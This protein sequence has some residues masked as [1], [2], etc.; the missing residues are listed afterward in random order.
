MIK[1][2][3]IF[4]L[5]F[6]ASLIPYLIDPLQGPNHC[7]NAIKK[8]QP[9][10]LQSNVRVDSLFTR[11]VEDG[12]WMS[13]LVYQP[14]NVEMSRITVICLFEKQNYLLNEIEFKKGDFQKQ[15]KDISVSNY[16]PLSRIND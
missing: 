8:V 6:A 3:F 4:I 2:I 10:F 7:E 1:F 9:S 11:T 13:A 14:K 15:L 5:A 12:A 16:N